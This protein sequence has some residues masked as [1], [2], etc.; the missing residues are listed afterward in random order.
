MT[1]KQNEGWLLLSN[2]SKL[3]YFNSD[4]RSICGRWM[5]FVR[6]IAASAVESPRGE[7]CCQACARRR[8]KAIESAAK[9]GHA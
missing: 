8:L 5:T 3:H 1:E 4:G 9:A 2:A 6:D 7:S